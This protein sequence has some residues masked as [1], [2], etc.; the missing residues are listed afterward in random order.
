MPIADLVEK[1]WNQVTSDVRPL[2]Q[3]KGSHVEIMDL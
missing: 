1:A 3:H 2:I